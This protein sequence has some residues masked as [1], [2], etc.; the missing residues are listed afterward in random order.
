MWCEKCHYGSDIAK[1][2]DVCQICGNTTFTNKNPFPKKPLRS[3]R[4]MERRKN[5][6]ID[7][8]NNKVMSE[9]IT[10]IIEESANL[11]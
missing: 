10:E 9:E 5:A 8:K 4:C 1:L 2:K 7:T 11:K 6:P 3:I